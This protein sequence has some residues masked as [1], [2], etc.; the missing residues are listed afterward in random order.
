MADNAI[1]EGGLVLT[2]ARWEDNQ[3]S[4]VLFSKFKEVGGIRT[5]P[6][7]LDV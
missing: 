4:R 5:G 3:G 2:L 7:G 6:E 1:V